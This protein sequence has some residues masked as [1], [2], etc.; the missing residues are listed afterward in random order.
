MSED[1]DQRRA[2]LVK[3][4]DERIA[5]AYF[6]P[7]AGGFVYRAP[8]PWILGRPHHYLVSEAQRD[9]IAGILAPRP[10]AWAK[11][12]LGVILAVTQMRSFGS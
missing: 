12:A 1:S 5:A 8:N 9:V 3:L 6:R 2:A 4:R 11:L 10:R 7:A